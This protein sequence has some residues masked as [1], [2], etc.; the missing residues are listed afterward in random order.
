MREPVIMFESVAPEAFVRRSHRI[1]Y[2]TLPVSL[3]AHALVAAAIV[4]HMLWRVEWPEQSPALVRAYI[5]A[6]APPPPPPPP[7]P[8]AAAKPQPVPVAPV[9]MPDNV[10]PNV[11]PDIIPVVSNEPPAPLEPHPVEATTAPSGDSGAGTAAI[12]GGLP[13]GQPGGV[14]GGISLLAPDNRV[15]IKRDAP[16]PMKSLRQEYP[17]YPEEGRLK[18]WEDNLTVRYVIGKDGRVKEITILDPPNRKVFEEAT[19]HAIRDWRF[20]PFI[21]AEGQPQEVV[22]E[23]TINFQLH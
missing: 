20:T 15:H 3:T 1:F 4:G 18:M 16:L 12:P 9:K 14:A 6:E 5:L 11:I 10:A 7:P 8:P 2:Q 19:R 17:V 13:G 23:L 22:H 21:D